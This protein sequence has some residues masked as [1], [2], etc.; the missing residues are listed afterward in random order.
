[1]DYLQ[2]DVAIIPEILAHVDS[3]SSALRCLD[4]DFAFVALAASR[5]TSPST[6][7]ILVARD[8]VGVRP[9]FYATNS[10]GGSRLLL[11][12]K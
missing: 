6:P 11:Q 3:V 9:L 2:T 12:V 7:Q 5:D 10:E 1:M 4:G 8:P